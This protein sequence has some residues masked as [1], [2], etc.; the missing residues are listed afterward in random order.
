MFAGVVFGEA[1]PIFWCAPGGRLAVLA[2]VLLGEAGCVFAGV[3]LGEADSVAG[4][5]QQEDW[6]HDRR[7][8]FKLSFRVAYGYLSPRLSCQYCWIDGQMFTLS[9]TIGWS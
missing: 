8:G 6:H 4:V 9:A 2:G 7:T 5:V 3:I 1:G